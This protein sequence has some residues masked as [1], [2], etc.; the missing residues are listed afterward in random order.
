MLAAD[1]SNVKTMTIANADVAELVATEKSKI[2]KKQ[3]K[4]LDLPKD[5][6]I[7]GLIRD[8]EA[9]IVNGQTQIQPGDHVVVFCRDT[10]IRKIEKYFQ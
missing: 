1:V 9:I 6:T 2:V 3:V 10:A 7:G 5:L 8:D 4:D